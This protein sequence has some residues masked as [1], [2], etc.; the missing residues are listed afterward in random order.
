MKFKAK[1]IAALMNG[2]VE[3]NPE[4]EVD[5]LS[6]IEEGQPGSL[7]FLSNPKYT[8]FIYTTG[9]SVIVVNNDFT[10]EKHIGGTLVRV[11]NAYLAF[12]KLLEIYNQMKSAKSGISEQAFIHPTATL[13][14]NV[15]IGEYAF[16]GPHSVIGDDARIFP[17]VYIGENIVIGHNTVIFPGVRIMDDCR[18]GNE[19]TIHPGVVIGS[20]G[21]GFA[22]QE[23]TQFQKIPQVGNTVLEDCV[24]VGANSTIDRATLGSTRIC[25]GVKIGN[26]VQIAH[27]SEIGEN[28]VIAA[29]SGVSGSVHIGRNCLIGGQVGFVGHLTVADNVKIAAQ[30]GVT[31]DIREEGAILMGSPAIDISISRRS[32]VHFRNLDTMNKKIHELEQ[33]L[34]KLK[35][36]QP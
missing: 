28:T 17:Q 6:K 25:K 19:C 32:F 26:Q 22:P 4:V 2:T 21:F 31:H 16:I 27:N 1:E 34:R 36:A 3:G 15:Y 18:I 11:E 35:T 7:T 33:E 8:P 10:T 14:K 5:R 29:M 13:G 30:S 12:A 20:D 24:E 9:A 23:G